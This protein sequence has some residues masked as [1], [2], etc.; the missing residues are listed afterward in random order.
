ML[1]KKIFAFICLTL[2]ICLLGKTSAPAQSKKNNSLYAVPKRLM[3]KG[4]GREAEEE[5]VLLREKFYPI[6]WS[7]D[8]KFAYLVEP[9][10]EACGCYFAQIVVQDLRTDKILWEYKHE[11]EEAVEETLPA[12][13]KKHQKEF[14][15]KLAQYGIVA[16][17]R[18]PLQNSPIVYG[19]DQLTPEL[20]VN[21]KTDGGV[22]DIGVTGNVILQL[23]SKQKGRKT[24]YE[25]KF[26]PEK[27]NSFLDAELSGSLV[28]PFEP[29]A[30][31]VMIETY[32]GWEGPPHV[33]NVHIVGA[34]LEKSFR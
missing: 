14:S 7:R 3:L 24:L 34:D 16:Q 19:S 4:D 30:A 25:M 27:Y 11:G 6:G 20:K 18:F 32:R 5:R 9:P 10:D 23:I 8:G 26:D 21:M 12:V 13:W 17:N 33:T 1:N 31:V 15:S 22:I 28:S 29:R 2:T